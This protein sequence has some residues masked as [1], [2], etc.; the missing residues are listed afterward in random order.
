MGYT[1]NSHYVCLLSNA[2]LCAKCQRVDGSWTHSE[3]DLN[4]YLENVDGT[5]VPNGKLPGEFMKSCRFVNQWLYA[6]MYMSIW[7]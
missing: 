6:C 5:I 7:Q 1:Q 3:L 4:Y 2:R